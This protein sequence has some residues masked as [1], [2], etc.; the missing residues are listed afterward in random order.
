[1]AIKKMPIAKF[2]SECEAA[3]NRKD[4]YIMGSTGQNPKK[5]AK[6]SWWFTQYKDEKQHNQALYWREHA[7]RVWDCNGMSEG[8]YKDYTGIDI[9]TKARYN[10]SDWC[11]TKG[12]GLIPAD[13]RIAG[14]AVFWGDKGKPSTIHH[15]GYLY[16]P[17]SA[18]NPKGDWYII[19][20]RG[21]MYGVVK[22]KLSSRNPNFWGYMDKYFDYSVTPVSS[23]TSSS[24]SAAPSEVAII[25][26]YVKVRHGSYYIRTEPNTSAKQLGVVKTDEKIKYLSTTDNG[27]YQIEVNGTTA[28]V[29]SK[30]G[31]VVKQEVVYLTVKNGNWYVRTESNSKAK[32]LGVVKTG[33][34]LVYLGKQENGWYS[35]RFGNADGWVSGKAF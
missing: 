19:E 4:G 27:W 5:W 28:Y 11:G 26:D 18:S 24:S 12:T 34:K 32:Q 13:K 1:M 31:D 8:L 22:T 7:T 35:V 25:G 33:E 3:L 2:V 30:C 29:S 9:N 23:S 16:K 6:N 10:Y 20:A 21:V 17:V 14:A 15:V